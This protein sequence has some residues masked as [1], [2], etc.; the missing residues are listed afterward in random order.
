MWLTASAT[1]YLIDDYYLALPYDIT[2]IDG[3]RYYFTHFIFNASQLC[4]LLL[5]LSSE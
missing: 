3:D 5:F 1:V 4:R 2:L